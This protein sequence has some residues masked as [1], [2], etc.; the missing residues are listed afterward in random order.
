MAGVSQ[1]L[2][3]GAAADGRAKLFR[4]LAGVL[5]LVGGGLC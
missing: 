3:I 1:L 4:V 2:R 5:Y